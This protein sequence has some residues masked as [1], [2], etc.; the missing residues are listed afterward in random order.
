MNLYDITYSLGLALVSPLLL[1]KPAAREKVRLALSQRMGDV[2]Q[3]TSDA[4]AVMIHAVSVGEINATRALIDQLRKSRGDLRFI[5]ST[6]TQ[7]GFERGTVLYNGSPDV[8]LIRYPLDFSSAIT[9]VLDRLRPSVVVLMEL[10]IWPN[11]LWHC[12]KRN[13]PVILANGRIT[14]PSYRK[15]RRIRPITSRMF[16]RLTHLCAQD[17]TYA[18]R[19]ADL[20]TP[21][22]QMSVIGTMKFDTATITDGISGEVEL[23]S[24]VGLRPGAEPIWVCGSTGPGEETMIL[25]VYRRL[26]ENHPGLR[27]VIVPRH[28]PRFDEV[29]AMIRTE[30]FELE[31]RSQP[32]ANHSPAAVVLGDTMGELRKFYSIADVVFVG[33]SLVDLGHRQHGSDM[34]EPAALGKPVIVGPFTTNF[35]DAMLKFRN[36]NAIAE[37]ANADE[38]YTVM[39]RLLSEK[40]FAFETGGR[41]RSVVAAEQ[42]ATNRH[43]EVIL[44]HIPKRQS[45]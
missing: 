27:L 45:H 2:P 11:F 31:R 23:A 20:G 28:P 26:R 39:R 24:A 16:Q 42:G 37:V 3:R 44:R 9:R 4:P 13:I 15:Y 18:S 30:G 6:T 17:E 10:E 35:A 32:S 22:E 5:V 19:F 12:S 8:T 21:I 25:S 41:A 7:T 34:I 1:F 40:A 43:A 36:N 38:L 33:R 29:A 14:E